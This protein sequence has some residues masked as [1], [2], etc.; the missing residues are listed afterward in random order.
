MTWKLF[1]R[2]APHR[3]EVIN[4]WRRFIIHLGPLSTLVIAHHGP[5]VLRPATLRTSHWILL[6]P[7][8]IAS[9]PK[10]LIVHAVLFR[11][12]AKTAVVA[13]SGVTTLVQLKSARPLVYHII[14]ILL[15]LG[16]L[17]APEHTHLVHSLMPLGFSLHPITLR[18]IFT[19]VLLFPV[20]A[21]VVLLRVVSLARAIL[22]V[23]SNRD[24]LFTRAAG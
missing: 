5:A 17:R 18:I 4:S 23:K 12:V 15:V 16:V 1:L 22:G 8:H 2:L 13:I 7:V 14:G 19:F 20:T 11:K 10:L 9:I 24:G 21:F 6:C 3:V